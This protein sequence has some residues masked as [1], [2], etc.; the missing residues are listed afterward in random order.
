MTEQVE[1]VEG[2]VDYESTAL[3]KRGLSKATCERYQY[4]VGRYGTDTYQIAC[5]FRGKKIRS[6]HLRSKDKEFSWLNHSPKLELFGQHLWERG[7]KQIILCE[8]EIDTMTWA[9]TREHKWPV[10]GVPGVGSIKMVQEN[11]EWLSS[12]DEVVIYMD[13]DDAGRTFA[14]QVAELLPPGKARIG[15][16]APYNDVNQLYLE[17]GAKALYATLWQAQ[18]W[19]P[20]ELTTAHEVLM[21]TRMSIAFHHPWPELDELTNGVRSSDLTLI[22]AGTNVGKSL[23]AK[24]LAYHQLKAGFKVGF[25]ALEE[26]SRSVLE[27]FLS[28]ETGQPLSEITALSQDEQL[29]ILSNTDWAGNIMFF[30][31]KGEDL[32]QILLP[33]VRYMAVGQECQ[34]IFIDHISSVFSRFEGNQR[35]EIDTFMYS[36]Q[37]LVK[38]T[39]TPVFA[40]CHLRDPQ[41]GPSHAEGAM[42]RLNELNGSSS[43]SRVPDVILGVQRNIGHSKKK[44]ISWLGLL[45]ARFNGM[46]VGDG[47]HLQALSETS[48]LSPVDKPID[49]DEQDGEAYGF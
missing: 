49:E 16:T 5:Y 3:T 10:V 34:M 14:Q 29:G 22:C 18:T 20:Q 8:G 46:R 6:Q 45:K 24:C 39:N 31:D 9:E 4:G 36:L 19:T 12:F 27:T 47:L 38:E 43:L 2:L 28:F 23:V 13:D 1:R 40:V 42:P 37:S 33:R 25:I 11:L 41:T 17:K 44:H 35:Q 32:T 30:T 26:P 7:G 21:E 48:L 15:S